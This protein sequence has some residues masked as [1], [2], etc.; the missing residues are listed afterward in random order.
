MI[1]LIIKCFWYGL[2][3]L[4]SR[5]MCEISSKHDLVD[6]NETNHNMQPILISLPTQ[7]ILIKL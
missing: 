6:E 3:T 4:L 5:L 1:N 2:L 7:M